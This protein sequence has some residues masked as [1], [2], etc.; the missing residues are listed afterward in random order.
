MQKIHTLEG[1]T[2]FAKKKPKKQKQSKEKPKEE[3]ERKCSNCS[4][5]THWLEDC[6]W[7]GGPKYKAPKENKEN[8]GK[9]NIAQSTTEMVYSYESDE[10][11]VQM[12]IASQHMV[13]APSKWI[14]DLGATSHLCT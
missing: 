1:T 14:I 7:E 9:A 10:E 3:S 6:Y 4:G 12:A 11:S 13:A 2:L 8:I 5:T